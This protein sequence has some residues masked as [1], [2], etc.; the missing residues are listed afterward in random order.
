MDH[1]QLSFGFPQKKTSVNSSSIWWASMDGDC[2]QPSQ[3]TLTAS[4][5]SR[6]RQLIP[7]NASGNKTICPRSREEPGWLTRIG[8]R[9]HD[10]SFRPMTLMLQPQRNARPIGLGIKFILRKRVMKTGH[11]LLHTSSPLSALYQIEMNCQKF[12]RLY[13]NKTSC[14]NNTW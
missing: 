12:T 4:G 6:F 5:C 13:N 7:C 2:S 9:P 14:R 10:Y 3:P 11:T 8:W 1:A